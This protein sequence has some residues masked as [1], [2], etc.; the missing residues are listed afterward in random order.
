MFKTAQKYLGADKTTKHALM[1]IYNRKCYPYVASNR[2]YRIQY[3]D[4][5]CAMFTTVIANAVGLTA[6]QF[7][8]EVS[9]GFQVKWAKANNRF[10]TDVAQVTPNDLII[11][12]WQGDGVL[13]HVGIVGE[14]KQGNIYI[15]EGNIRDTVGYRTVSVKSKSIVGFIRVDYPTKAVAVNERERIAKLARDTVHGKYGN[16]VERKERLGVDY[17]AVQKVINSMY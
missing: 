2:K 9:V 17:E 4:N 16:G 15:I 6:E 3:N 1:D 14:V 5:W 11:Y 13:D 7:P 10:F 12:D 8:Y